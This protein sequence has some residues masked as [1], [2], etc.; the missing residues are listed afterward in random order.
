MTEYN[1]RIKKW[2]DDAA[3]KFANKIVKLKP[4]NEDS[5]ASKEVIY[6]FHRD[7]DEAYSGCIMMWQNANKSYTIGFFFGY[8]C[9]DVFFEQTIDVEEQN[10]SILPMV[11]ENMHTLYCNEKKIDEIIT[12]NA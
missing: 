2:A 8:Y 11:I 5:F 7:A 3:Q 6:P 10:V 4:G 9:G 1:Y 12:N